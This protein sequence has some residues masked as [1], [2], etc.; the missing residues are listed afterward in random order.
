VLRLSLSISSIRKASI[1]FAF[2]NL[3]PIIS[4]QEGKHELVHSSG[5]TNLLASHETRTAVANMSGA[6]SIVPD[7][8]TG[9][10]ATNIPVEVPRGRNGMQPVLRLEYR[11][12]G[13]NGI[14]GVGWELE[15]G[16]I[17][18]SSRLGVNFGSNEYVYRTSGGA[19][20]LV[21]V[22]PSDYRA[23]IEQA[24]LR[25]R[26]SPADDGNSYWEVTD[27]I[28]RKYFYG[29]TSESRMDDPS[30]KSRV[31]RW[32]LSRIVD[33]SHNFVDLKYFKDAGQIYPDEIRYTGG[34]NLPPSVSIQFFRSDR[35]DVSLSYSTNFAVKTSFRL[36][37]I[38]ISSNGTTIKNYELLYD[39]ASTKG[40]GS[41]AT[42][43]S[44]LT[45]VV[46]SSGD[47]REQLP[48]IKL[49]YQVPN[50]G[51]NSPMWGGGPGPGIPIGNQCVT[52]DFNGDGKTDIACYT[53]A[54]GV[55]HVALSTGSG[56]NSTMWSGGPGPG[57]P[58]GNQCV[59]GDFNGDGKTDMACY[60]AANGVWHVALSAGA[61]VD[62]LAQLQNIS[63]GIT[64]IEYTASTAYPN[65]LLPFSIQSVSAIVT[66]DGRGGTRKT[67]LT[68]RGGFFYI[69]E[70]DFRGFSA[71]Q[72]LS[73][74][75]KNGVRLVRETKFHQGNETEPKEDDPAVPLGF[76]KGRPYRGRVQDTTGRIYSTT[77]TTYYRPSPQPPYF[78]P[79]ASSES[80]TCGRANC[81]KHV[82]SAF[83][84]DAYGNITIEYH[85][86]NVEDDSDDVTL[87]RTF[88][89]NEEP[90]IVGLQSS[91]FLHKGIGIK[92][93][94]LYGSEYYYDDA[95][96]CT[97]ASQNKI[98]KTG[99]LTRIVPW[100]DTP[101]HVE[102][103][104]A[105]D[106]YGNVVCKSD[107]RGNTTAFSY[108]SSHTF[109]IAIVDALK[110]RTQMQY[111]GVDGERS[112]RGL[113]GQIRSTMDPN[114]AVTYMEYDAFGRRIR[115]GYPG[116]AS[117]TYSY[118]G[119]GDPK[120]QN[121]KT[122]SQL[123]I[124]S[125]EYFDGLGRNYLRKDTGAN[126]QVVMSDTMFDERGFTSKTSL[127]HEND[128]STPKYEEYE[129]DPIGR[130]IR[131]KHADGSERF[132]CYDAWLIAVVDEN[133]HLSERLMDAQ[134]NVEEV[135]EFT[136]MY[137]D[138]SAVFGSSAAHAYASTKYHYDPLGRPVEIVDG[139]GNRTLLAFDKLGRRTSIND[140]DFGTWT[141]KYDDDGNIIQQT[142][143][144][145]Q[146]MYLMYDSV[147]RIV[148]KD[149]GKKKR[150]G[151]GDIVYSYDRTSPYGIGRLS[152]VKGATFAK[153]F[154]YDSQGRVTKVTR[155][156]N[157]VR[158][159]TET[160]YDALGRPISIRY[161]DT[162]RI[163]YEYD[164]PY[165]S[166]VR[167]DETTYAR[168][169]DYSPLG[170]PR[171]IEYGNGVR[172]TIS[173]WE[174]GNQDC[175]IDNRRVCA[176]K[177]SLSDGSIVQD[178]VYKY[179]GVG[180]VTHVNDA[181]QGLHYLYDD[182]DRLVA[183]GSVNEKDT[184]ADSTLPIEVGGSNKDILV[185]LRADAKA[186]SWDQG[187]AYN[188][189]G[190]MTWNSRV[191][192]YQYPPS[193]VPGNHPHAA[194]AAGKFKY[195]YDKSG[196]MSSGS[197][198]RTYRF[199]VD[200]RLSRV[201]AFSNITTIEYDELGHRI[202]ERSGARVMGIYVGN[203]YECTVGGCFRFIY[204]GSR[205]IA[206]Q[207]SKASRK[208]LYIHQDLLSSTTL[209][210]N[211]KGQIIHKRRYDPYGTSSQK[212]ESPVTRLYTGQD[213]D[214]GIGLYFYQSRFYDPE[215]GR[216]ISPDSD[217]PDPSYPRN[218]N[219]YA[220][221]LNNPVTLNDPDGHFAWFIPI[222]AG[223]VIGGTN[224][225]INHENV[226]RGM[227]M[228]A[229][230]GGF[231][232]GATYL[233]GPAGAQFALQTA[234][235]AGGAATN[236]A[237]WGGDVGNAALYGA[238][239]G[240]AGYALS[241]VDLEIFNGGKTNAFAGTANYVI[242]SGVHG[243]VLEGAYGAS[244]GRDV[245]E[246][247]STGF[248]HGVEGSA[249]NMAMGHALGLISWAY[250]GKAP[251]WRDGA[252]FY[253]SSPNTP[254][255][256]GE[257][258]S[259]ITVGNVITGND[260]DRPAGCHTTVECG[261]RDPKTNHPTIYEHELTH[262][263]QSYA[264]GFGYA[265]VNILSMFVGGSLALR[266]AD[267]KGA[268]HT[269]G[270]ME[271]YWVDITDY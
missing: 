62:L 149:F 206:R 107:S 190:N 208:T 35:D 92:G 94:V 79:V 117:T 183:F 44:L 172:S 265:P 134:G 238:A 98:P 221:A 74:P 111:Y 188:Q 110:H 41:I 45:S 147:N 207:A 152:T 102:Q 120:F 50:G 254:G 240:A 271:R 209:I 23:K 160:Q 178:L 73:P 140:P 226:F 213:W 252:W 89:V 29:Q 15:I 159:D 253:E 88:A 115:I 203:L 193:G 166:N 116:G 97:I 157:G 86:N 33:P 150:L 155:V 100:S 18:R 78:A 182:L 69:P 126:H 46:L 142:D 181:G 87:V 57:I 170:Q 30:D 34:P 131:V 220:Y 83:E 201:D 32:C 129:Y 66:A 21:Q 133:S 171:S 81:T 124:F 269:N 61:A 218:L 154:S 6:A 70:K 59:T 179:D 26:L 60:T 205:L 210:T 28:G 112:G 10:L 121:V 56:W 85:Y 257:V 2:C 198:G 65:T 146:N 223:A 251:V 90:W 268:G 123:G 11:S 250:G 9:A 64:T 113:F 17:E 20:E 215:L 125:V 224:A 58:I 105:Y 99:N 163:V 137:H 7:L 47:R 168:F 36:N 135:H 239:F 174:S 264:L 234:A 230:A 237:I 27:K 202:A 153:T 173:L 232:A 91:E 249:V 4:A 55:W 5:G 145:S 228:G 37:R 138:C 76:M 136:G 49:D 16:A 156:I 167:D 259:G 260:L 225:A 184:G 103:R 212:A 164:G 165:I 247:V 169:S 141:Y 139:L 245:L 40:G 219:R 104:L 262:I 68:Y 108:D 261:G 214:S 12:T 122:E 13:G 118:N 267:F 1:I 227:A 93:S 158:Y 161:P 3:L 175:P 24:F 270:F 211:Y 101:S 82:K 241:G 22:G 109:N 229:I 246:S 63:G 84:Y 119:F 180:N 217:S 243:A 204:A 255:I 248:L 31:F 130:V 39:G 143:A 235:G 256:L 52:G 185:R 199:G 75:D 77:T 48:P 191:G 80:F 231:V 195:T 222:I 233:G 242:N 51:W 38:Q 14:I 148:Q 216:F 186:I 236:A 189:I 200:N 43:R 263:S 162:S 266:P 106:S 177:T 194:I 95:D 187:F 72:E 19:A 42:G 258:L 54:N 53:A 71:V 197:N 196:N 67:E 244:M 25:F 127:P 132:S 128:G 8:F 96:D 176:L 151:H 192:E 144:K 114:R